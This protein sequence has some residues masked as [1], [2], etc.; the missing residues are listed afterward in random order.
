MNGERRRRRKR[1]PL[2]PATMPER[3]VR[4]VA[5]EF[6]RPMNQGLTAVGSAINFSQFVAEI[7]IPV[8]F[9]KWL[10][11]LRTAPEGSSRTTSN[12]NSAGCA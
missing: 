9:R 6:L 2:A 4:K 5:L 3:E 1:Q 7:Y 10:K 8:R 11:A 12:L